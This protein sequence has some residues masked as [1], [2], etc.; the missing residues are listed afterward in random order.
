MSNDLD[1]LKRAT[2]L[3]ALLESRGVALK[4]RGQEHDGLCIA[5]TETRPSMQVYVG[6]DGLQRWHCKSCGA[7][8]TV[9]D[10]IMAL[11]GCDEAAAIA[12]LKRNGFHRA[13]KMTTSNSIAPSKTL[14]KWQHRI[15]PDEPPPMRH[16]EHGEPVATWRYNDA[17]GNCI[18]YV[19]RY[20]YWQLY[21]R[22]EGFKDGP[23]EGT[24]RTKETA[25]SA[26]W[27]LKPASPDCEIVAVET[28]TYLPWTYGAYSEN[29]KA[30]WKPKSWQTG[31]KPIYGL[32][33][34][35]KRPK[36]K[37]A[38]CEG[39]KSADAA[40]T[41]LG[42]MVCIT[43]AGGANALMG[44]DWS[45][46]RGR[47][48]LLIPDADEAG[49]ECM[50]K[51]AG[52][53]LA[54]DCD[55]VR[56]ADTS[57][58]PRKWDLADAVAD[59]WTPAQLVEW[60]K[61]RIAPY[62]PPQE[63][64][65][66]PTFD[67]DSSI[68]DMPPIP[69]D[70]PLPEPPPSTWSRSYDTNQAWTTPLDIFDELQSPIV[71]PE[72]V[73]ECIREWMHDT[74]EIKGVD[75][76]ILALS[77]VTACAALL[78]DSI[79]IQ[80]EIN[81]PSWR[82][83]AR[84]WGA[85]VG[86]SASGKTPAINAAMSR[87]KK[88]QIDLSAQ[89]ERLEDDYKAQEMAFDMQRK[90]YIKKLSEADATAVKPVKPPL[91]E[92]SRLLI[93]DVTVDK[94]ADLL[95]SCNR[96]CIVDKPELAGWFGSM[97][98]YKNGAGGSDRAAWLTFFDG[99]PLYVDRIGR[100]SLFVPN[101]GGCIIGA[102]Q[103]D[104]FSRIIDKLPEDGL[105]QRFLIV[106]AR[107]QVEGSEKPYNKAANDRFH[108]M[109]QRIFDTL[110]YQNNVTLSPEA[111]EVR[112]EITSWAFSLMRINFVSSAMCSHL[113][114]Y[115]SL[116]ARLMLTFHAIECADRRTHPQSSQ[117]SGETAR[118]VQSFIKEFLFPHAMAFYINL[119]GQSEIG[120]HLRKL[121]ELCLTNGT[122][123]ITNR[124]F[125][126]GWIGWR[127]CKPYDQ[128]TV[129]GQLIDNGW[130]LPAPGARTNAKGFPT[131][132]LINPE[133]HELHAER[134]AMEIERRKLAVD[135]IE[136]AKIAAR[137]GQRGGKAKAKPAHDKNNNDSDF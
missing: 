108:E 12:T 54:I 2:D 3:V 96:G 26:V 93:Q 91:P 102:I 11:D 69:D 107:Q 13:E 82:E 73:P 100:G 63:P 55:P 70:E 113:G 4:K 48:V 49:A 33:E 83:S 78:H 79:H 114:K 27:E 109:Q 133:I 137:K 62:D 60:I 58:M 53:L 23:I 29:V 124:D 67:E 28:K 75:P 35:A 120:K 72:M 8:G 84:L 111:N 89:A 135:A 132:F 80:P 19:A 121:G 105:L 50:R 46:L 118:M 22:K 99:G 52:I 65:P 98:A 68:Y 77:A 17:E 123:E 74:S 57:D 38:I 21:L 7:G 14:N 86:G 31:Q 59:G 37:V 5:H 127:H 112:R 34:L 6:D 66:E 61:P 32:D 119:V 115:Q 36:A 10:A 117:I 104:A 44:V 122:N 125:L 42:G 24:Y 128:E 85:I 106:N 20:R 56:M 40:R 87:L 76:S 130:I 1:A 94:L 131:R 15:A 134:K 81:N 110:V 129:I 25:E 18:G 97:D 95:K 92:I 103:P 39:E 71:S 136:L 90:A 64:E 43:W 51:L 9:V 41:L 45:A 47:D 101:F 16:P 126:H 30:Q 88:I 116:T